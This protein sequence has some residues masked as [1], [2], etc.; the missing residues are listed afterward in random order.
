[1]ARPE[2]TPQFS[3]P[4][5]ERVDFEPT[6]DSTK[7]QAKEVASHTGDRAK[8]V[9]G[10]AAAEAGAVK[11][12]ATAAGAQVAET[13]KQQA[14]N[15]AAEAKF[16]TRRLVDESVAELKTQAGTGQ[17]HLA[18]LIRSL[19][20]E[21]Q[22]MANGTNES[23]PMVDLVSRAERFGNDAA[24]WLDS[25]Q[26]DDVMAEVRRYAARNPWKFLAI[27]AGVGFVGARLAR[28]LQGAKADENDSRSNRDLTYVAPEHRPYDP[29][30]ASYPAG[31]QPTST[32]AYPT[33]PVVGDQYAEN[34][35]TA[36]PGVGAEYPGTE[37][38]F[39]ETPR[40]EDPWDQQGLR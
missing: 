25:K 23:G 19:S 30:G 18:E 20:G 9:A 28:G 24:S 34:S 15:V 26:P 6:S 37:R 27:S 7:D 29:T 40:R 12:T 1:M 38:P 21:L 36:H 14:G 4:R 35:P 3:E 22:S 32:G 8:D 2:D 10:T 11:D 31:G 17:H 5:Y 16:Q 13:A 39:D 33:T